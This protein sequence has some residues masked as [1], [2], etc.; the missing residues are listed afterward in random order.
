MPK[1]PAEIRD[2]LKEDHDNLAMFQFLVEMHC[3][4]GLV[5]ESA[6]VSGVGRATLYRWRDADPEFAA[7]WEESVD[8]GTEVLEKVAMKRAVDGSDTLLIFLLKSRRPEIY[9]DRAQFEHVG[10]NG[11][12][13]PP[14]VSNTTVQA[15][16]LVVP[17]IIEDPAAWTALVQRTTA[18]MGD[19]DG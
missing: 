6:H 8:T 2:A 17:G 14:P 13:L 16:V 4:G 15:G 3:C 10:K 12:E 1:S 5:N 18:P 11:N 19:V 7:A 9:R